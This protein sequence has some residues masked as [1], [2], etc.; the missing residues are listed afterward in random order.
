MK[1]LNR[2]VLVGYLGATPE[3]QKSK[4][5]ILFSRVSLATHRQRKIE[6]G[7]YET[8]T[9][10]HKVMIWGKL[11]ERCAAHCM[12]GSIIAIDG[13]LES[14]KLEK[15]G[16]YVNQ[17]SIIAEEVQFLLNPKQRELQIGALIESRMESET[18]TLSA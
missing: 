3:L 9:E 13:H 17:T 4:N 15:E 16:G 1:G 6:E 10:W 8:V 18:E 11:A 12:K 7:K 5:G 2:V 14:F